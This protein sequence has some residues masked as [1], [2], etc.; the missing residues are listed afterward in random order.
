M[1]SFLSWLLRSLIII[2]V[3]GFLSLF[4]GLALFVV[5]YV[6]VALVTLPV[7]IIGGDGAAH[8]ITGFQETWLGFRLMYAISFFGLLSLPAPR[9]VI[10][11][12][13]D[14]YLL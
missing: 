9:R 12:R 5:V 4:V 7:A 13:I 11:G 6:L 3:I 1:R 14:D 2:V 8:A 10:L